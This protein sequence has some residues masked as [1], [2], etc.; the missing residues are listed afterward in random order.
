M[1]QPTELRQR[2][3]RGVVADANARGREQTDGECEGIT[4]R[5][6]PIVWVPRPLGGLPTEPDYSGTKRELVARFPTPLLSIPHIIAYTT[7]CG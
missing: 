3:C 5:S 4:G 6:E 7:S 1:A 2:R